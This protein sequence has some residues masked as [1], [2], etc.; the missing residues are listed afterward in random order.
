MTP[1]T[2]TVTPAIGDRAMQD[3]ITAMLNWLT[4]NCD[5]LGFNG[6]NWML[7]L[8]GG[9]LVYIAVL[10]IGRRRQTS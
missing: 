5:L 10:V 8:A 7:L 3:V 2:T 9:L 1:V 4:G 6:Q